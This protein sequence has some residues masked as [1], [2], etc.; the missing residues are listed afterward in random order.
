M[1]FP[2]KFNLENKEKLITWKRMLESLQNVV[3]RYHK[4]F[5]LSGILL[6]MKLN[7]KHKKVLE[8]NET[9]N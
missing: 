4:L 7:T 8:L 9:F 5:Y 3:K 2:F 1:K 6:Y